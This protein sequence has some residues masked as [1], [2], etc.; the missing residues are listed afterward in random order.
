MATDSTEVPSHSEI[1]HIPP[2][3]IEAASAGRLVLFVGA[4]VS[5][6][7]GGPSWSRS[8]ENALEEIVEKRLIPFAEAEQ[9]RN[10]HPKKKLSIAMDISQDKG[11]MLDFAHIF[12][13]PP[14]RLDAQVYKDL[15]SIGVPI[16][17]TN[18]DEERWPHVFGQNVLF[19][20]WRLAVVCLRGGMSG[21][22]VI[23]VHS[24]RCVPVKRSVRPGLVIER[25]VAC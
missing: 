11:W 6:L 15:Y 8:A 5:R 21:R 23:K 22:Q 13:P 12:S 10:E 25:Q 20:K 2:A 16:V 7:A 17:T 9:L 14:D 19:L 1:P 4:G 24:I 3:I 18:Y